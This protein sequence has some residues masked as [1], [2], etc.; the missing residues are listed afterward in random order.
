MSTL[1]TAVFEGTKSARTKALATLRERGPE[2]RRAVLLEVLDRKPKKALRELVVDELH[3]VADLAVAQRLADEASVDVQVHRLAPG[4]REDL[5]RHVRSELRT[6][7]KRAATARLA[8][9]GLV[10][11]RPGVP[12]SPEAVALVLAVLDDKRFA[13]MTHAAAVALRA[14]LGPDADAPLLARWQAKPGTD[15]PA[16]VRWASLQCPE[17]PARVHA[18][19]AAFT[20][21]TSHVEEAVLLETVAAVPAELLPRVIASLGAGWYPDYVE[22]LSMRLAAS[23]VPVA[24]LVTWLDAPELVRAHAHVARAVIARGDAQAVVERAGDLPRDVVVEALGTVTP[25]LAYAIAAPRAHEPK[26]LAALAAAP[27]LLRGERWLELASSA[28]AT[29]AALLCT[30]ASDRGGPNRQAAVATLTRAAAEAVDRTAK[31][32]LLHALGQTGHPDA[33]M[34]LVA[35]LD[36]PH[37][38]D[39]GPLVCTALGACGDTRALPILERFLKGRHGA[40][41]R[42]AMTEIEERV[43]RIHIDVLLA[44]ERD[45][46]P[47]LSDL[48]TRARTGDREAAMVLEDALLERGRL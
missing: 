25:E 31:R 36:D 29:Y 47:L 27:S 7:P 23:E 1:G 18:L 12:S 30:M 46:D 42:A 2:E 16:F 24:R 22:A 34:A 26:H 40:F 3:E 48:A 8:S 43:T 17:E 9:V 44:T 32:T 41:V 5:F 19:F 10:P 37:L 4:V 15:R 28:P 45:P 38:Q 11:I 39:G 35:A 13:S 20:G 6:C 33:T 14:L 21:E